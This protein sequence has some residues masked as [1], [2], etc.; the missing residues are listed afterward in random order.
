MHT[1]HC[2]VFNN[3]YNQ[4]WNGNLF[5]LFSLVLNKDANRVEFVIRTKTAF[6]ELINGRNK[7]N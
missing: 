3:P 2:V 6:I 1:V 7:T 5:C 4:H